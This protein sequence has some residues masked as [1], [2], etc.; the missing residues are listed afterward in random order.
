VVAVADTLDRPGPPRTREARQAASD[1][2]MISAAVAL[3]CERGADATTLK[4]VG[5]RA[6]YSRGLAGYRFGSKAGLWAFLVHTIGEEW[7]AEL[8]RAAAGTRGV[9]TLHA[10]LDAHRAMLLASPERIRAFYVL[11]FAAVGPDPTLRAQIARIHERRRHDVERWIADGIAAGSIRPDADGVAVAERFVAQ[12]DGIVY[13][14]LVG[15]PAGADP[16]RVI[17]QHARLKDEMTWALARAPAS[18]PHAP[19]DG[20]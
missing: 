18:P 12:I 11:W 5:V 6:G 17:R 2:A 1:A 20:G 10:A 7:L 9:A 3:I 14:W 15:G 4:D 8:G 16:E 19:G 13:A